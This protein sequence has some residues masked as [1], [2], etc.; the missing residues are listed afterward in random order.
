MKESIR[1]SPSSSS[2]E[3]TFFKACLVLTFS[4]TNSSS[5][6]LIFFSTFCGFGT[7]AAICGFGT[8]TAFFGT[9]IGLV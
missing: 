6:F 1:L 2:S 4:G 8:S 7:S 9:T 5:I 3:S